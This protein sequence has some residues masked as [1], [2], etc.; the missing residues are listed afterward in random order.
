MKDE[1]PFWFKNPKDMTDSEREKLPT[2]PIAITER[3]YTIQEL[4]ADK[5]LGAVCCSMIRLETK[6]R[7][8]NDDDLLAWVDKKGNRWSFGQYVNGAWF[9]QPA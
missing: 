7:V 9:K 3:K 1:K 4:V 2:G 8:Y 5:V 6:L